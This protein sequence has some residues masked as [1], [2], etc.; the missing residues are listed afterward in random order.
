MA[1]GITNVDV[2]RSKWVY[3]FDNMYFI[4]VDAHGRN[5]GGGNNMS[6]DLMNPFEPMAPEE[7]SAQIALGIMPDIWPFYEITRRKVFVR[8]A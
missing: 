2:D 4:L 7:V 8:R 1:Y 6:P 5:A 3:V